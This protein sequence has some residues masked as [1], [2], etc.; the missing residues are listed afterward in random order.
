MEWVMYELRVSQGCS[1][2]INLY[3]PLPPQLLQNSRVLGL[4]VSS[5]LM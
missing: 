3:L 4:E 2:I 5:D 1:E